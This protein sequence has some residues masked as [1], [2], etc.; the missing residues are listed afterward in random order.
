M[1][2]TLSHK[3]GGRNFKHLWLQNKFGPH[4]K[5]A[6][7]AKIIVKKM[8]MKPIERIIT[9]YSGIPWPASK[10]PLQCVIL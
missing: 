3:P 2:C 6:L 9:T 5:R 7:P 1:Q 4:F 10:P 8:K